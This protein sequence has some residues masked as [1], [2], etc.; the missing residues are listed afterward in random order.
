MRGRLCAWLRKS[1]NAGTMVRRTKGRTLSAGE[2]PI[3]LLASLRKL[4][5]G[6]G[7]LARR[8]PRP[9]FFSRRGG[10]GGPQVP[11]APWCPP[12]ADAV[13]VWSRFQRRLRRRTTYIADGGDVS[14]RLIGERVHALMRGGRRA[15]RVHLSTLKLRLIARA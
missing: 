12:S 10:L 1:P 6:E 8:P 2:L 13:Y 4:Q 3:G 9:S 7:S 11:S 5:E 15:A 14:L